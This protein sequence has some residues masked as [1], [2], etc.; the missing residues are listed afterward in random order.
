M[1]KILLPVL[2]VF[3]LILGACANPGPDPVFPGTT[4]EVIFKNYDG[5]TL[6]TTEVEHGANAVY[7]GETPTREAERER[8]RFVWTGWDGSLANIRE[9][10]TF[11]ATYDEE[12]YIRFVNVPRPY[13]T[14]LEGEGEEAEWAN[15]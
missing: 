4:Y 8:E 1:K 11:T 5:S 14:V 9:N 12:Y 7:E 2:G 3:T 6:Y 15:L 13:E 10:K